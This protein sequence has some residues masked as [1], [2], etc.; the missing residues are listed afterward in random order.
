MSP[1][2]RAPPTPAALVGALGSVGEDM[3]RHGTCAPV[4]RPTTMGDGQTPRERAAQV[5][6]T[7]SEG[8]RAAS[9]RGKGTAR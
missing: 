6:G 7:G 8:V 5:S 2:A 4:A 3:R 1:D 9:D